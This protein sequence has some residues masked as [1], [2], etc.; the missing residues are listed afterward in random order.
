LAVYGVFEMVRRL[1]L[2]AEPV[3]VTA[4]LKQVT[5]RDGLTALLNPSAFSLQVEQK[6]QRVN[7]AGGAFCVVYVGLDNFER[8]NDG[9]GKAVGDLLLVDASRRIASAKGIEWRVTVCSRA[10][11][12][13]KSSNPWPWRTGG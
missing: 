8:L 11:L 10:G 6:V 4:E 7:Q 5:T 13:A 3:A 1:T 9:F 12:P 2:K